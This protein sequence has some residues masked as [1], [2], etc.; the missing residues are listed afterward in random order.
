MAIDDETVRIEMRQAF[1]GAARNIAALG[2]T[3][4]RGLILG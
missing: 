4:F 3:I 1:A 2:Q